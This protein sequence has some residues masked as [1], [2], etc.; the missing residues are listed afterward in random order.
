[1]NMATMA[2]E[3]CSTTDEE[4]AFAAW[5]AEVENLICCEVDEDTALDF[6]LDGCTAEEAAAEISSWA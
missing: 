4:R 2:R 3:E 6:Y 5:R 1:M